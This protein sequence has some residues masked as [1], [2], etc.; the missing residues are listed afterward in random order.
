VSDSVK[1]NQRLYTVNK[2]IIAE[3]R[4]V[5]CAQLAASGQRPFFGVDALCL[6]SN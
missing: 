5:V 4:K 6:S 2:Q 3:L 1:I